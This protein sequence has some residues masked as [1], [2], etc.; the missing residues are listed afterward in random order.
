MKLVRI[1]YHFEPEGWWAESADLPG[2]TAAGGTFDEVR[3]MARTGVMEFCG[4]SVMV[5]E[6]GIPVESPTTFAGRG[7]TATVWIVFSSSFQS[8][9]MLG[10]LLGQC[11]QTFVP[12]DPQPRPIHKNAVLDEKLEKG[13]QTA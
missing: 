8:A 10:D 3:L 7:E 13:F 11:S 1:H 4:P 2:W 9:N 5:E 12:R 6:E